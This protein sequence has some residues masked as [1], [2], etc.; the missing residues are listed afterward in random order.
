M[1]TQ[2]SA[3][4]ITEIVKTLISSIVEHPDELQFNEVV[5]K[6]SVVIGVSTPQAKD[7]SQIIGKR[8]STIT[9]IKQVTEQIARRRKMRCTIYVD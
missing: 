2:Q 6:S 8:G 3:Q 4:P 7:V 1:N 9:A 5:G